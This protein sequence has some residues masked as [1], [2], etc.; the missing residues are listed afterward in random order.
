NSNGDIVAW[1]AD[2]P[3]AQYIQAGP[4]AYANAGRNTLRSRGINNFDISV[5]KNIPFRERYNLRVRADFYNALNHAQYTPG[6]INTVSATPH[7]GETL[8]LNPASPLFGAW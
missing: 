3:S 1:V 8:Y 7:V 6:R 4:G 5:S 2:D